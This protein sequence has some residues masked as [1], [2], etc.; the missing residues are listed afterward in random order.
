MNNIPRQ[1][2]T[3]GCR[4]RGILP[5]KTEHTLM[6]ND[7]LIVVGQVFTL[8]LMMAVGFF[9]AKQGWLHIQTLSQMSHLLLYI[10]APCVIVDALLKAERTPELTQSLLQCALALAVTY[11]IYMLLAVFLFCR[12]S[13][14]TRDTLRFGMIY[15]NTSFMGLPLIQGVLGEAAL[16]YCTV[17]MAAFNITTWTHGAILMGG[18]ENASLKKAVFNPGVIGCAI[19]FLLFF[20]GM[21]LPAPVATAVDYVADLNTPL[22][23][24]I[25]GG[26]MAASNLGETFRKLTLYAAS[27]VKLILFPLITALAL[28]PFGLN[29]LAYSTLVILSACPTAGATGIFAQN[30]RRDSVTAAQLI[31]LS[32]LLSILSLPLM[33]LVA[34]VLGG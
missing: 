25:I 21:K 32:T 20:S 18:R 22:A 9:L 1:W 24:V 2:C 17:S 8:F 28:L 11:A 34:R 33:A 30:F 31:T 26:Q 3:P 15:G 12:K 7:I 6:L 14:D 27:A 19:G 16:V 13:P 23:M 29:S 10:V 4:N 5:E